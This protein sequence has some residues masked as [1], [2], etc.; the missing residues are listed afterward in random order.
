VVYDGDTWKELEGK[1]KRFAMNRTTRSILVS[2]FALT[3]SG[4]GST[5]PIRYYTIESPTAPALSTGTGTVSLVV[6]SISGP[7]ILRRSPIAYR[8]GGNEIGSY[9]YS[10]WE[11]PPVEMI[12]SSL[13]HLLRESGNYQSV[14]SLSGASGGQ[15]LVRGRLND[16]EEVD[17]P[18]ITGLVSMEFEL[19]DRK[20]GK[21]VWAHSYSQSEPAKGKEISAVVSAL[22][23][24]LD[25]GLK[26][27]AAGL[28]QFLSTNSAGA[29][30]G[31]R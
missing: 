11:E 23:A 4:C 10:Q 27:V 31:V 3:L 16:F 21:V 24:N 18:T 26:E 17:G 19:Y 2:L 22:D 8:V 30:G 28:N 9:Q 15:F 29:T 20:S 5:R 12:Q 1:G 25:R 13:I 7:E 6:A 14:E